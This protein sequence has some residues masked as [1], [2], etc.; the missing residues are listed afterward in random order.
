MG[1]G[2]SDEHQRPPGEQRVDL[3]LGDRLSLVHRQE[4]QVGLEE[5]LVILQEGPGVPQPAE[6]LE[7]QEL[8]ADVRREH[9][10][11]VVDLAGVEPLVLQALQLGGVAP[12]EV[13]QRHPRPRRAHRVLGLLGVG[14]EEAVAGG[15]ILVDVGAQA[16]GHQGVFEARPHQDAVLAVTAPRGTQ[17]VVALAD[18][19]V[20]HV[21]VHQV[22]D[23]LEVPVVGVIR[24]EGDVEAGWRRAPP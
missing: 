15:L 22:G 8:G 19:L 21:G 6:A 7:P 13:R 11:Q 23:R 2:A 5:T 20:G 12:L 17:D 18:H 1:V 10:V 24:E 4:V 9:G 3:L 14:V 16:H